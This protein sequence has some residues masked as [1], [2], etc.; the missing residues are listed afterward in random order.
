MKK[1]VVRKKL[2]VAVLTVY[3]AGNVLWAHRSQTRFWE[4]RRESRTAQ[5]ASF[6]PLKSSLSSHGFSVPHH[7]NTD[8]TK[9]GRL[10]ALSNSPRPKNDKKTKTVVLVQDIHMNLEAQENIGKALLPICQ[11]NR[12]D[13]IFLEGAFQPLD[14]SAYRDFSDRPAVVNVA[15]YLLSKLKISGPIHAALTSQIS[16]PPLV[17]VDDPHLYHANVKAYLNNTPFM[18][19]ERRWVLNRTTQLEESMR[20]AFNEDLADF[21]E[22]TRSYRQGKLPL[23]DYLQIL[24]NWSKTDDTYLNDFLKAVRL[25]STLNFE[26]VEQERARLL[27]D[28]II[29]LSDK[30]VENLMKQT[31]SYQLGG[32]SGEQ[33]YRS[34]NDLCRRHGLGLSPYPVFRGYL[35]YVSLI[36]KLDVDKIFRLVPLLEKKIQIDLA[37]TSLERELL[38]QSRFLHLVSKLVEFSLTPEEWDDYRDLKKR[39]PQPFNT[40]RYERFYL[41]A[42]K[43]DEAMARNLMRRM[44]ERGAQ[45]AVLVAGG[46]HTPGLSRRLEKEGVQLLV[47]SPNTQKA[48]DGESYLSVFTQDKS[49]LYK[50]FTGRKLFTPPEPI[51]EPEVLPVLVAA[52]AERNNP[53]SGAS[54]AIQTLPLGSSI[55][56]VRHHLNSV[57]LTVHHRLRSVIMSVTFFA[58]GGIRK[59]VYSATLSAVLFVAWGL[60]QN[61][62]WDVPIVGSIL[63]VITWVS[64]N[65]HRHLYI[66]KKKTL[67]RKPVFERLAFR[68]LFTAN[69]LVESQLDSIQ[70]PAAQVAAPVSGEMEPGLDQ[71]AVDFMMAEADQAREKTL[72]ETRILNLSLDDFG[73]ITEMVDEADP[74][75]QIVVRRTETS[76]GHRLTIT[77]YFPDGRSVDEQALV[78]PEEVVT[79]DFDMNGKL[80]QESLRRVEIIDGRRHRLIIELKRLAGDGTGFEILAFR[81]EGAQQFIDIGFEKIT[82]DMDILGRPQQSV[83]EFD[84]FLVEWQLSQPPEF[85]DLPNLAK[86]I[87]GDHPIA[88]RLRMFERTQLSKDKQQL[89]T[90]EVSTNG[91][92]AALLSPEKLRA[93]SP[94]TR[95]VEEAYID[96]FLVVERHTNE[97]NSDRNEIW[98]Q[99][100]TTYKHEAKLMTNDGAV[101]QIVILDTKG[102][103]VRVEDANNQQ[104][105]TTVTYTDHENGTTMVIVEKNP[106]DVNFVEGLKK[107]DERTTV[108]EL[109]GDGNVLK[110]SRHMI[111]SAFGLRIEHSETV[112]RV[113]ENSSDS[114][115]LEGELRAALGLHLKPRS[116]DQPAWG[117]TT[118]DIQTTE[119]GDTVTTIRRNYSVGLP[120]SDKVISGHN[121]ELTVRLKSG[122]VIREFVVGGLGER[123]GGITPEE[124][125]AERS[126][127]RIFKFFPFVPGVI[128]PGVDGVLLKNQTLVGGPDSPVGTRTRDIPINPPLIQIEG[129]TKPPAVVPPVSNPPLVHSPQPN[130]PPL[131]SPVQPATPRPSVE[132]PLMDSPLPSPF[133]TKPSANNPVVADPVPSPSQPFPSMRD[134]D[135]RGNQ[136]QKENNSLF[137]SENNRLNKNN[138][139]PNLFG[140]DSQRPAQRYTQDH[141]YTSPSNNQGSGPS[142]FPFSPQKPAEKK[143][144]PLSPAPSEPSVSPRS[145]IQKLKRPMDPSPIWPSDSSV[146][147]NQR[148]LPRAPKAQRSSENNFVPGT[149]SF[150]V[151][152][153]PVQE[154]AMDTLL[155]ISTKSKNDPSDI[156]T[157]VAIYWAGVVGLVVFM[158]TF[159]W[160]SYL[161]IQ[162]FFFPSKHR[163]RSPP[164][165]AQLVDEVFKEYSDQDQT[166]PAEAFAQLLYDVVSTHGQ[167]EIDPQKAAQA[168]AEVLN[169]VRSDRNIQQAFARLNQPDDLAGLEFVARLEKAL[170]QRFAGHEWDGRKVQDLVLNALNAEFQ[171]RHKDQK[172]PLG[173]KSTIRRVL[174]AA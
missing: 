60:A 57:I 124:I 26:Q 112:H 145:A 105:F 116:S 2:V 95:L 19:Q 54:Q 1:R 131:N 9:Y 32:L 167:S 64:L 42:E 34:L 150:E 52:Q 138:E 49:P 47:F 162:R 65:F 136:N 153:L 58:D 79:R 20:R 28:L 21:D 107:I 30:E 56:N 174:S 81:D 166:E 117:D 12:T 92:D 91:T 135:Q 55:S 16:L 76:A 133:S 111:E 75:R 59:V 74:K 38:E 43:R 118:M 80:L 37:R 10:T 151:V 100:I 125:I 5:L 61:T 48:G 68:A 113:S 110:I 101:S 155:I 13:V 70:E 36:E 147:T 169:A 15:D 122:N 156:G 25:E 90:W 35:V 144:T 98:G 134:Q 171:S 121:D 143:K 165:P 83:T 126:P 17:G 159:F 8:S 154:R 163:L 87:S 14:L 6:P 39:R 22:K 129:A 127:N 123:T 44:E 106:L 146:G 85:T 109:D 33:F 84:T 120:G 3:F 46:F 140:Q 24:K 141:D 72:T 69:G 97:L 41:M 164:I 142:D 31:A 96:L 78:I 45:A 173:V 148:E 50:L 67:S 160:G 132:P 168:A 161:R 29:K 139:P 88:S 51:Q 23:A 89:S 115:V 4:E 73:R 103:V 128:I 40:A 104:S 62:V 93:T 149:R 71:E 130:Y 11:N 7:S 114:F 99:R 137:G 63:G 53:G 18:K 172:L 152:V 77:S 108:V 119:N 86:K 82:S 66:P 102:R 158:V 157:I 94:D 170:T 27:R